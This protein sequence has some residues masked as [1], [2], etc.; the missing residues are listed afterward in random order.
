MSYKTPRILQGNVGNNTFSYAFRKNKSLYIPSLIEGTLD[1]LILGDEVV[2]EE[3]EDGILKSCTGLRN[4]IRLHD[5]LSSRKSLE[6]CTITIFDNHNHA[7]YFWY[8]ALAEWILEAWAELIH[9]DEHSDLWD[10][11]NDIGILRRDLDVPVGWGIGGGNG[12]KIL[13]WGQVWKHRVA[14]PEG[15]GTFSSK[16]TVSDSEKVWYFTNYQCNVG[17]YIAPAIRD[18]IVWKVIRI[19][20]DYQV[21]EYMDYTPSENS[22]LNIDLDFFSPEMSFI[23]EEKKLQLIRNLLPKVKCITIATSPYFIDQWVAIR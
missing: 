23:D 12:E 4:F 1:D 6:W 19:E 9:I 21:D 16:S 13:E 20:N 17:N 3:R 10:N 22:I 8:E 15:F 14:T 7:V 5:V 18:G 11:E 2:F